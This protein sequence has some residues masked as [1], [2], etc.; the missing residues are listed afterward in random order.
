LERLEEGLFRAEL[1][2]GHR[3][4]AHFSRKMRVEAIPI[5]PGNKV[6]LEIS[7]YDMSRGRIAGLAGDRPEHRS[8]EPAATS[9]RRLSG[10]LSSEKEENDSSESEDRETGIAE[11][12]GVTGRKNEAEAA[13]RVVKKVVEEVALGKGV[14]F[15]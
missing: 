15:S 14:S 9:G 3:V 1:P 13:G 7:P 11:A 8:S 5:L 10:S 12:A 6:L 4:F 2:N